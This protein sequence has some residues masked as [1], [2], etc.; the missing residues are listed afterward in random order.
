MLLQIIWS[1]W[2]GVAL[3]ADPGLNAVAIVA[4]SLSQ[5][6]KGGG[7]SVI[8]LAKLVCCQLAGEDAPQ[9][10]VDPLVFM[11]APHSMTDMEYS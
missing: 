11:C 4:S 9:V 8:H 6:L 7:L 10:P 1:P 2:D 5:N 3:V